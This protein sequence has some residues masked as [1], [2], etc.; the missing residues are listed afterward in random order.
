MLAGCGSSEI[1]QSETDD[2]SENQL[3]LESEENIV[4]YADM[5][6]DTESDIDI[7]P[8]AE[9]EYGDYLDYTP[10]DTSQFINPEITFRCGVK[11][12][13]PCTVQDLVDS[14]FEFAEI[15]DYQY[16]NEPLYKIIEDRSSELIQY[17]ES[18]DMVYES[19]NDLPVLITVIVET[20]SGNS[21]LELNKC[22]VTNISYMFNAGKKDS[23]NIFGI[24]T[25]ST[26][27]EV[28]ETLGTPT[29]A[30]AATEDSRY[31]QI[32][33]DGET[34]S[35]TRCKVHFQLYNNIVEHFNYDDYRD[36]EELISDLKGKNVSE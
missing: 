19:E 14:G 33:Y 20:C 2:V 15:K 28:I 34:Y 11:I 5:D 24:G 30:E 7:E 22:I 23:F 3:T 26:Y 9:T 13:L 27:S 18:V 31:G 12:Q 29:Y 25:G 4:N 21:E 17:Y 8:I 10:V 36:D 16:E 35:D 32:I 1:I 6:T